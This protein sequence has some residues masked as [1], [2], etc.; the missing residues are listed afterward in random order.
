MLNHEQVLCEDLSWQPELCAGSDAPQ[1]QWAWQYQWPRQHKN[2]KELPHPSSQSARSH[3]HHKPS[4]WVCWCCSPSYSLGSLKPAS[5]KGIPRPRGFV[6]SSAERKAPQIPSSRHGSPCTCV[7]LGD[8]LQ[9]PGL[10]MGPQQDR[11]MSMMVSGETQRP[12]PMVQKTGA[13]LKGRL[14][15]G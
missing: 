12:E 15:P 9:G 3:G 14:E 7:G 2:T 11:K 8:G 13:R 5:S 4:Y 10:D 1:S 6:A